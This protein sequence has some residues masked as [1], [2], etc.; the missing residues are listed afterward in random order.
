MADQQY[1]SLFTKQGLT[2]LTEAINNGTKLGISHM[3]FGDGGGSLPEPNDEFTHLVN[4]V[5]RMPINSLAPDPNNANWLRAEAVIPSAVGGFN[6]RELGLYA[7][8]VLV[9]YSNYP[10]TTKPAPGDGAAQIKSF[11]MILQIDNVANFELVIDPDVVLATIQSVNEAKK[12]LYEKTVGVVESVADLPQ[13]WTG[14]TIETKS[15]YKG[16]NKGGAIYVYDHLKENINNGVTCIN[17]WVLQL[18]VF[19]VYHAGAYGDGVTDDTPYF[20]LAADNANYLKPNNR[21]QFFVGAKNARIIVPAPNVSYLLTDYINSNG[22]I[23]NWEM[24]SNVLFYYDQNSS[25]TEESCA[26]Y[27]LGNIFRGGS[28][29]SKS[30]AFGIGGQAT[31][32][33]A[34]I[35]RADRHANVVGWG[36]YAQAATYFKGGD[37]VGH[38]VDVTSQPLLMNTDSA[39]YHSATSFSTSAPVDSYT[40]ASLRVGMMIITK[41]TVPYITFIKSYSINDGVITFETTG[42]YIKNGGVPSLPIGNEG[43][44]INPISGLWGLNTNVY[45]TADGYADHAY[46][47]ELL[48][49]NNRQDD[50]VM[51]GGVDENGD[52]LYGTWGYYMGNYGAKFNQCGFYATGRFRHGVFING[53][54]STAGNYQYSKYSCRGTA[55]AF[56]TAYNAANQI[57]YRLAKNQIEFGNPSTVNTPFLDWHSS[58]LATDY[59]VRMIVSGGTA[60]LGKGILTTYAAE[61]IFT[62]TVRTS[63]AITPGVSSTFNIGASSLLW[64]NIYAQNGVIQTSDENYKIDI[65]EL[66]DVEIEVAKQCAKLY[67]TFKLKDGDSDRIHVGTI[68]Q[69]VADV[70]ESNGLDPNRYGLYCYDKWDAQSEKFNILEDGTVEKIQEAIEAGERYAIRYDEFNAF[71]NAGLNYWLEDIE[72]RLKTAQL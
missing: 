38:Y 25:L 10:P 15:Y 20:Q 26:K 4:E 14:R 58:G 46:G 66:T 17:G 11:R 48:I 61:A 24:D 35:G 1:Y 53:S 71:V 32:A 55:G 2:L 18:E 36:S 44:M 19:S 27:L 37:S 29:V 34:S 23:I 41:H 52:V 57:E 28:M 63:G 8:N 33:S 43:V 12:E 62:G 22:H 21:Q 70:F 9:A 40:L 13:G 67:R 47:H 65:A 5:Y 51:P 54:D 68:A 56:F 6:I 7:G 60:E 42:F 45:L 59:D 49:N 69:R 16:R 64:N 39:T 30:V 72:K 3:A 50:E 31:G